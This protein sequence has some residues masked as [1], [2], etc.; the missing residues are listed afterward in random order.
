MCISYL[1]RSATSKT[2]HWAIVAARAASN[3]HAV[4]LTLTDWANYHFSKT[5][6]H[7]YTFLSRILYGRDYHLM[8]PLD[9]RNNNS[10]QYMA[11]P[12][13]GKTLRPNS[14]HV[15]ARDAGIQQ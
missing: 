11:R 10:H 2:F 4:A 8:R 5:H 6:R 1:P 13:V 7:S 9:A 3:A 15:L 14:A 12:D